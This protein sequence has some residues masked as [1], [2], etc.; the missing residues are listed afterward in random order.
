MASSAVD[1]PLLITSENSSSERR[2][3]PSWTIGHLK[4]RL[5]PITGVPA[6]CQKLTLKVGSQ[7][8]QP[9][10]AADEDSTQLAGWPLQAYA[11]IHVGGCASCFTP[12]TNIRS[13]NLTKTVCE[14]KRDVSF[15]CYI[16]T[17]ASLL[18]VFKPRHG[19]TA[20]LRP[21]YAFGPQYEVIRGASAPSYPKQKQ[22][23]AP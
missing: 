18:L 15:E 16:N 10:E 14:R 20:L 4:G 21:S 22:M 17:I 6:S 9:I 7:T 23:I 3:T 2:V 12:S 11:E 5:E 1:I 19:H 8:P 13:V